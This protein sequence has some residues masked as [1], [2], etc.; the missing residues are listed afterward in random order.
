LFILSVY[1]SV[2]LE[3]ILLLQFNVFIYND[4]IFSAIFNI[5][6]IICLISLTVFIIFVVLL[7][8]DLLLILLLVDSAFWHGNYLTFFFILNILVIFNFYTL[9]LNRS[10]M[11]SSNITSF[12]KD[13]IS[14]TENERPY[15]YLP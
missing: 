7:L 15:Q 13:K 5:L 3:S 1:I 4:F 9:C 2:Y 10:L 8:N 6:I 11:N 12:I 14:T